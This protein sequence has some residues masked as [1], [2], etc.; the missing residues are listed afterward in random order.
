VATETAVLAG[1][2]ATGQVESKGLKKNAIGYVSNVVI[3]VASTA[4][5]YSIAA[6]LGFIVAD[7]GIATHAP[8]VLLAA[9]VPMLFL[10]LGYRFLNKAD[11]DAGTTF[12]W[13]TRAFGPGTGWVNGWAIFL[14]DV[15]VMASLGYVAAIYTFKLFEWEWAETHK[16]AGLVGCVL[17]IW[18]MTWICH[19]GIELSAR[20]QQIMLSFEVAML[21]IFSVVALAGSYGSNPPAG[22][23][24][25]RLSW[26][27][28]F[29]ISFHDLIVAMLLGIFIYWGWDS[30]VS[31]NEESEDSN[32]GPGR[33]AVVS[34]VLL[35][36]IYMLVS[37]GAQSYRGTGFI[38]NEENAGDILNALGHGVLGSVGVRFLIVAVLTSAAAS[39]QT[40]ILP[41]ARTTLSMAKWGAIP[42][43]F[44]TVHK[45]FLTPTASTWGFG[46]IS[47]VVAVPLILISETVLELAVVA[48][49][50]PVCIYYGTTGFACA[51]YYRREVTDSV[52]KFL[53]VG[54]AP[55]LA[56]LMFYGIGGYAIYFYGKAA[57]S[58]GKIYL[59][60]T[61]PIWFGLVG[62]IVGVALMIV[63]RFYFRPFFA[64]KTETA[65][66]GL[67]DMPVERAPVHLM[68]SE[69]VT[70]GSHLLVPE[71]T[72]EMPPP[73]PP[74]PP[75]APPG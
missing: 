58:E 1:A 3:G 47:V 25:P 8:A 18:L 46:I 36:A 2:P 23:I 4:P 72:E 75:S 55:L 59:G 49:G 64:R 45:R 6:T 67:L 54:V 30:G 48:L 63:S 9:F 10:S 53:L 66:E 19:R 68:G 16:I 39:T 28:P 11:P 31:V 71:A 34:T 35:V 21:V 40:T 15:L 62:M 56:G 60:L 57:N 61:L 32:D 70:H 24:H 5:A 14:A 73:P 20:I 7:P 41:T 17:W 44:G 37:A 74:E 33:A 43:L 38:A 65:P 42:S 12:A 50:I 29:A 22:S 26:F 27:N 52:R 69:H 51:W 13:T